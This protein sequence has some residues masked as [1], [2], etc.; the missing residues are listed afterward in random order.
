M[1][2][3]SWRS[4]TPLITDTALPML[5]AAC[6]SLQQAA[7]DTLS[8]VSVFLTVPADQEERRHLEL[9]SACLA[10]QYDLTVEFQQCTSSMTIRFSRRSKLE[11][12]LPGR[13]LPWWVGRDDMA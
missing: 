13:R 2:E 9:L 12:S 11:L 10:E 6:S 8:S 3:R 7:P 5:E 4:I 1:R